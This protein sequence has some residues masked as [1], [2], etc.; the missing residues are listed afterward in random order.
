MRDAV[1]DGRILERTA[2]DIHKL[3]L[4]DEKVEDNFINTINLWDEK[5]GFVQNAISYGKSDEE[6]FTEDESVEPLETGYGQIL[7]EEE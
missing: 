1:S 2:R 4:P 7:E 6:E 5:T 3:L